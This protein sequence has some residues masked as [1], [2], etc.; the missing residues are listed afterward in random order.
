MSV[1]SSNILAE[2]IAAVL[3]ALL[4][5]LLSIPLRMPFVYRK[6]RQLLE[7]FGLTKNSPNLTVYLST[8][9]VRS[10][11]SV[12]FQGVARTFA[13]PA[14]PSAE[15]SIVEPLSRIFSNP[16]LD[17]LP[18]SFRNWLAHRVHWSF[19]SITPT[20]KAS[21]QDKT[22][23]EKGN[24]FTVGSRYYNSAADLYT[25]TINPILSMV[26]I[27]QKMMIKVVEGPQSGEVFK[28]RQGK[29]DDLAIVEKLHDSETYTTVF[30]AAGLSVVGTLGAVN[31]IVDK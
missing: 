31:F 2:I 22:M 28:Q 11:G 13:G 29:V 3:L 30:F 10:G 26:Q 23:V 16:F 17:G 21:P 6:R 5:W 18:V 19:K 15:L 4:L 24:L 25:D 20:F 1:L 12:D 27:N 7:F 14:I 9:F 8:V